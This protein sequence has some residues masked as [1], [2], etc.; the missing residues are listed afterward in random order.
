MS[1]NKN[2]VSDDLLHTKTISS[3]TVKRL[4]KDVKYIIKNPLTDNGIY[5][6]H[7]E[8]NMLVGYAMIVGPSDTPYF[9]GFYFFKLDY[10][11]D[12][13]YS[14]PKV[15]YMT[16]DGYT[17]YNPNLYK[18][19][20]VC[21]SLLNTWSGDKWSSCQTL[22]SVLITLCSLLNEQPLLN[23]PGQTNLSRDFIPYHKCIE[24]KN[25]DFCYCDMI[26]KRKDKIPGPFIQFYS[27]MV[28]NFLNSYDKILDFVLCKKDI[29]QEETVHIYQMRIELNYN[30]LL[31]KLKSTKEYIDSKSYIDNKIYNEEIEQIIK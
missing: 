5:Y 14:P 6:S 20:K 3:E 23:E 18:C 31:Q 26:D 30:S 17:R 28:E 24:Y 19:G 11:T 4:L 12:Y 8:S 9:G 2:N 10:P 21:V 13:P 16:N 29:L 27:F 25:I 22:N 1:S 15:T 7:D